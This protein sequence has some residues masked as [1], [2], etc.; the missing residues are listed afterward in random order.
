[1]VKLLNDKNKETTCKYLH[2]SQMLFSLRNSVMQVQIDSHHIP[3]LKL[4]LLKPTSFLFLAI[5]IFILLTQNRIAEDVKCR[6]K[7]YLRNDHTD[8]CSSFVS[9]PSTDSFR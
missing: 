6:L 5:P 3:D 1:M 7:T 8:I 2:F 4:Q 9:V